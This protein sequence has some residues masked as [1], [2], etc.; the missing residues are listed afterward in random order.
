MKWKYFFEPK[1]KS[2]VNT[3]Y[4]IYW[5]LVYTTTCRNLN[6]WEQSLLNRRLIYDY[7]K[8]RNLIPET[9]KIN[10][11]LKK[12]ERQARVKQKIDKEEQRQET[13]KLEQE[14]ARGKV[15]LDIKKTNEGRPA[16]VVFT[17]RERFWKIDSKSC[18]KKQISYMLPVVAVSLKRTRN[19]KLK[20]IEKLGEVIGN[21]GKCKKLH[22]D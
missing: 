17:I 16:K 9:L 22:M 21:L 14:K 20:V 2:S 10:D 1:M 7:L 11:N 3:L 4:F 5:F 18:R 6:Q 8:V 12:A 19:K 15:E 13:R